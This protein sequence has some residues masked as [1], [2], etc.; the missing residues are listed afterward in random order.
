AVAYERAGG[1]AAFAEKVTA[2]GPRG[3]D[4]DPLFFLAAAAAYAPDLSTPLPSV[5]L[6]FDP[7]TLELRPEV[8]ARYRAQDPLERIPAAA[9]GL[10]T[11]RLL[12]LDAGDRDEYGLQ[13][14]ARQLVAAFGEVGATVRYDE[15]EGGHRGTSHRYSESLPILI[16]ALAER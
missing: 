15:F 9:E 13:Y 5:A 7:S 12:Y 1:V 14:A 3:Q 11:M 4:F 6:P 8:W 10:R 16:G 2:D